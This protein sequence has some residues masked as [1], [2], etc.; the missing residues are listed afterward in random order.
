MVIYSHGSSM[1]FSRILEMVFVV[2]R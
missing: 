1:T 2:T